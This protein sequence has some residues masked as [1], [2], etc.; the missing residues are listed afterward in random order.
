[1]ATF[2]WTKQGATDVTVGATNIVQFNNDT[3]NG[4]IA[5]NSWNDGTFVATTSQTGDLTSG[6]TPTNNKFISQTG[7]TA[8]DSQVDNGAGT[9]DLDATT[10]GEAALKIVFS[11]TASVT[12]SSVT[13][14]SYD[15]TTSATAAT[16]VDFRCAEVTTGSVDIIWT[17][18]EGSG[19]GMTLDGQGPGTAHTWYIS[20]TASPTTVGLKTALGME[21]ELTYT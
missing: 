20:V 5:V 11:D 8:G 9:V 18:A 2:V 6:K 12:T 13:F 21:V 4:A 14:Y 17:E 15:G 19:A 10:Q 16:G 1:M 7:G 3:F